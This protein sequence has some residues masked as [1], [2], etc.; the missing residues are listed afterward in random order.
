MLVGPRARAWL[1]GISLVLVLVLFL[2]YRMLDRRDFRVPKFKSAGMNVFHIDVEERNNSVKSITPSNLKHLEEIVNTSVVEATV[3]LSL[4]RSE[5][6]KIDLVLHK[7]MEKSAI[8]EQRYVDKDIDLGGKVNVSYGEQ[9]NFETHTVIGASTKQGSQFGFLEPHDHLVV[10]NIAHFI[11]FSC[12]P[13]KFE[14]L[15]SMLSVHRIMKADKIFFHTDCE[16]T[17]EWWDEAVELVQTLQ[18]VRRPP[19]TVVFGRKLNPKWPEHAADVARLQ[20]LIEHGGIYFDTDIFVLA[21]LEP[22]RYYDYVVGRPDENILNNGIIL[23]NNSSKFLKLYYE[24]Y[25]SYN[26]NCWGCTS[27][28]GHHKVAVKHLDLLHIEPDSM[29]RPPYTAWRKL[30]LEKYDWISEHFTIHV[31][32]REFYNNGSKGFEFTREN[33]KGLN[34]TVGEMCRYIYYGSPDLIP[35]ATHNT[36]R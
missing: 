8:F 30:F 31:W 6:R 27:V 2:T 33:I 15:V 14:N 4:S 28:Q 18:V 19:P 35:L 24:S 36:S 9:L 26:S 13:F 10:P 32:F 7:H 12:H 25:K 11:W 3:P 22:L 16:P 5:T 29:V 21:P 34:T 20:I 1:C 17:G 23:A